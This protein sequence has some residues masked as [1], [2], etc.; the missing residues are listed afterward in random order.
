MAARPI[1]VAGAYKHRAAIREL[2][3]AIE[4][5]GTYKQTRAWYDVE[6]GGESHATSAALD[7]KA[8]E[9]AE[10]VV[11]VMDDATYAY[12]GTFTEI[13]V[14]L[15]LCKRIIVVGPSSTFAATNVFWHHHAIQHV[16]TVDELMSIL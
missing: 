5:T 6:G 12:R 7:V 16:E 13:G 3:Q 9:A 11:A 1:Y 15:G 2:V 10:L 8:V 4:A 14:A